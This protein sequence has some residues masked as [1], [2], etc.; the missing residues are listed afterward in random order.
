M[1][2]LYLHLPSVL[3]YLIGKQLSLWQIFP[4]GL[5]YQPEAYVWQA[6]NQT[7]VAWRLDQMSLQ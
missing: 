4:P 3:G 2:I 1:D 5:V 6:R 7:A